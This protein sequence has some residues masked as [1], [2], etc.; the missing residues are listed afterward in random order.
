MCKPSE[1]DQKYGINLNGHSSSLTISEQ[2]VDKNGESDLAN[3]LKLHNK[4]QH[5]SFTRL[6][7]MARVGL[8]PKRFEKYHIP[9][10][11]TCLYGKS[12]KCPKQITDKHQIDLMKVNC[13]NEC[14]SVDVLESS[15]AGMI[16]QMRHFVTK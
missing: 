2:E 7:E 11:S 9:L 1:G 5:I 15:V 16:T 10:C 6:H 8:I 4:F 3:L 14:V 12:I 13:P